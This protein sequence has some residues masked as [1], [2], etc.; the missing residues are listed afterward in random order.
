MESNS[1]SVFPAGVY[2]DRIP[3]LD[4]SFDNTEGVL[5]WVESWMRI[6]AMP[7]VAASTFFAG[8]VAAVTVCSLRWRFR[9]HVVPSAYWRRLTD[10]YRL[11]EETV[12]ASTSAQARDRTAYDELANR[13]KSAN[14][15]NEQLR[16]QLQSLQNDLAE[17][18]NEAAL[19]VDGLHDNEE[20]WTMAEDLRTEL[21]FTV[22]QLH[23]AKKLLEE[24]VKHQEDELSSAKLT[25]AELSQSADRTT[26]LETQLLDAAERGRGHVAMISRLERLH[27]QTSDQ[28]RAASRRAETAQWQLRHRLTSEPESVQSAVAFEI[29]TGASSGASLEETII[30][31]DVVD[32]P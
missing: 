29:E 23:E 18:T 14:D 8:A 6:D 5:N 31:L 1:R 25:I 9:K 27:D 28:L 2:S 32:A 26:A 19:L 4:V 24:K 16:Q 12:A 3:H 20:R 30:D 17:V 13:L 22:S 21:E 11:M 7:I 10:D 15:E